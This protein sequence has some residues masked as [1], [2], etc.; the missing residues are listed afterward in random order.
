MTEDQAAEYLAARMPK[1]P[2]A[3]TLR[4]W[5]ARNVGPKPRNGPFGRPVWYHEAELQRWLA[6]ET[7][8]AA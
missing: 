5:R 8:K 3:R 6:E 4:R 1:A 7:S 2:S